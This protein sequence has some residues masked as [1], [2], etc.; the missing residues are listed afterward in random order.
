MSDITISAGVTSVQA[1]PIGI[2]DD[3]IVENN[4]VFAISLSHPGYVN[5]GDYTEA[6]VTIIDID[7]K[8][9]SHTI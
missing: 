8:Y 5:G 2:V 4:E 1:N 9:I 7:R 6:T 3:S